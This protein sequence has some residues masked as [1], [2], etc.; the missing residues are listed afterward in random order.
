M[1][2]KYFGRRSKKS[3]YDWIVCIDDDVCYITDPIEDWEKDNDYLDEAQSN[4]A[5]YDELDTA[6]AEALLAGWGR[7]L[8]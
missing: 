4:P 8:R 1:S 3:G 5:L 2:K 6:K 7:S